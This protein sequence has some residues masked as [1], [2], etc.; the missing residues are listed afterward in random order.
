MPRSRKAPIKGTFLGGA[1]LSDMKRESILQTYA[2]CGMKTD[3]ARR[4]GVSL[5]TVYNVLRETAPEELEEKR[6]DTM[7]RIVERIHKSANDALDAL[8]KDTAGLANASYMQKVTGFAILTDKAISADKHLAERNIALAH[9]SKSETNFL[10]K[11]VQGMADLLTSK[12]TGVDII[13]ARIRMHTPDNQV[14]KEATDLHNRAVRMAEIDDYPEEKPSGVV[15]IGDL[16]GRG[17][18]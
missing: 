14:S 6:R 13:M 16:D 2:L 3:T 10:P 12:I 7:G 9:D 11:D 17:S 18:D 4:E 8:D 5:R 15:E 1:K